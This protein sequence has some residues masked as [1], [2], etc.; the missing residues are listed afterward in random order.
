MQWL[1]S[2]TLFGTLLVLA[3]QAT[4]GIVRVEVGPATDGQVAIRSRDARQQLIATAVYEDGTLVDVTRDATWTISDPAVLAVDPTGLAIP[5]ADGTVDVTVA[6]D[7]KSTS[8]KVAVSGF[9]SPLP[10]NFR[11]Q[12]VPI[13]T[14]LGCNGGG[15][16]GKSGGQNGFR[17]SLLGFYPE[18]DF[19]FLRKESRGAPHLPRDAHRKSAPEKSRRAKPPRWR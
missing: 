18:D 12:I 10:V 11:N 5:K 3:G 14:K 7:G 2:F 17:L 16:H 9:A 6:I 19:E 15:C 4:A 13:F 8:L 1:R